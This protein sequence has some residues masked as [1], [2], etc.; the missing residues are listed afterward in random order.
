MRHKGVQFSRHTRG[1]AVCV[2]DAM[3]NPKMCAKTSFMH[4]MAYKFIIAFV[5]LWWSDDFLTSVRKIRFYALFSG[6]K[7]NF[8]HCTLKA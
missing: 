4:T 6:V 7:L 1:S 8:T 2:K 5:V 3:K